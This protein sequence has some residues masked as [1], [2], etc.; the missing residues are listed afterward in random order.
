[1]CGGWTGS[2]CS[3]RIA[4]GALQRAARDLGTRTCRRLCGVHLA[5]RCRLARPVPPTER[6]PGANSPISART[7]TPGP[8]RHLQYLG[9]GPDPAPPLSSLRVVRHQA[10]R[11]YQAT[12]PHHRR[13]PAN[14]SIRTTRCRASRTLGWTLSGRAT[15]SVEQVRRLRS[16]D[17]PHVSRLRSGHA[18]PARGPRIGP[19]TLGKWTQRY[20]AGRARAVQRGQPPPASPAPARTTCMERAAPPSW[21][22]RML[23]RAGR[24]RCRNSLHERPS[25]TRIWGE[26]GEAGLPHSPEMYPGCRRDTAGST[27]QARHDAGVA[28]RRAGAACARACPTAALVSRPNPTASA[29]PRPEHSTLDEAA[30][31]RLDERR[32]RRRKRWKQGPGCGGTRKGSSMRLSR[33]HH[34]DPPV[35][36][37]PPFRAV[38]AAAALTSMGTAYT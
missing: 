24:S 22:V 2:E 32:S 37:T 12:I 13:E 14:S 23:G 30:E 11:T 26:N 31:V 34:I 27:R 35:S 5:P 29:S 4:R 18:R 33:K 20:W 6:G 36:Y 25:P 9:R 19:R 1:M 28:E 21:A 3:A 8:P 17:G 38:T 7:A 16:L 15:V 10:G